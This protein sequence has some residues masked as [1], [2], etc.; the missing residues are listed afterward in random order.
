MVLSTLALRRR[1]IV[2]HNVL[3]EIKNKLTRRKIG[4]HLALHCAQ[5]SKIAV[6]MSIL[7]QK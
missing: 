1:I 4:K 3:T 6:Y 7:P 2:S 5:K